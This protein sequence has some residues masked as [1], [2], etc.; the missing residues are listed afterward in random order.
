MRTAYFMTGDRH[1][2][3]DA[4]QTALA[5]TYAAWSRACR[6][7]PYAYV[8]KVLSNHV[9]D[10]WRR[11]HREETTEAV[12]DRPTPGD[13]AHE[14]VQQDWLMHALGLLTRQERT[15]IVLRHFY[16]LLEADIA[17]EL[18]V[19]VGT[20]KSTNARA[21]AKLRITVRATGRLEQDPDQTAVIGG[22]GR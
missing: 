6:G 15:I 16:D 9:I 11:P 1:Q 13:L 18:K 3:E 5:R 17:T 2:A 20:V 14:I 21:L 19:S 8:R 7:D 22:H 10:G 4:V 12:P